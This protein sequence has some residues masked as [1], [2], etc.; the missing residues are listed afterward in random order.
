MFLLY[1]GTKKKQEQLGDMKIVFANYAQL[2][3]DYPE[4]FRIKKLLTTRKN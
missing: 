1:E 4:D 3:K 2:K